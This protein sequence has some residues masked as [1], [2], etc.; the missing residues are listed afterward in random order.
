MLKKLTQFGLASTLLTSTCFAQ[1]L[2]YPELNVSP[3]ASE[4]ILMEAKQE[5]ADKWKTHLPIQTSALFTLFAGLNSSQDEKDYENSVQEKEAQNSQMTAMLVGGGWLVATYFLSENYRP[6]QKGANEIKSLP[7]GSVSEQ[8]V[9]ERLAEETI[10]SASDLGDRLMWFSVA[11]QLLAAGY[12]GNHASKD[13]QVYAG[14]AAVAAFSPIIFKYNWQKVH[15]YH[16]DYKKRIYAPIAS[17]GAMSLDQ[18]IVP[19]MNLSWTF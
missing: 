15:R 3:K 19:S 10:D 11:S 8:L 14:I 18:K 13:A 4:R 2:L 16:Q 17:L 6:Y 9:R 1:N 12:V 5:N 7:N